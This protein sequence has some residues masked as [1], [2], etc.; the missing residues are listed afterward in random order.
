MRRKDEALALILSL[1][2]GSQRRVLTDGLF[3]TLDR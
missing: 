2:G 3:V 1:W